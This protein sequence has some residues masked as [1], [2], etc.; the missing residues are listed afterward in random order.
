MQQISLQLET[1]NQV[2]YVLS[3]L[4]NSSGTFGLMMNIKETAEAQVKEQQ[5]QKESDNG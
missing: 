3:Q 4:P 5:E 2:I 1:I